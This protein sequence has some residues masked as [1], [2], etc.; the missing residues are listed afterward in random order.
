[1]EIESAMPYPGYCSF[2][3]RGFPWEAGAPLK[4]TDGVPNKYTVGLKFDN[5]IPINH[6]KSPEADIDATHI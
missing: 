2:I 3:L 6:V 4:D 5:Q 1:M